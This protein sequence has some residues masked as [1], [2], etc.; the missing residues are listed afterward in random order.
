MPDISIA[1]IMVVAAAALVMWF[2]KYK[3]SSSEKRMM[4]MLQRSGLNPDIATQGDKEHIIREVRHRCRRCQSEGQCERWLAGTE[5][6]GNV[7][8]PNAQVFEELKYLGSE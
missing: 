7:F 2:M 6:G 8:C 4:K 3:A 1:V 5:E